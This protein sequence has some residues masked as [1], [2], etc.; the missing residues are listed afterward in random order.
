MS[1]IVVVERSWKYISYLSKRGHD[2]LTK[3]YVVVEERSKHIVPIKKGRGVSYL[4]L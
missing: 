3:E 1:V 2:R 4:E